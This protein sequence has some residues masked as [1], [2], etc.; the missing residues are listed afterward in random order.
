MSRRPSSYR[1]LAEHHNDEYVKRAR[2]LGYR[3][4][5]V[6]K[7]QEIDER[8]GLLRRGTTVIDLGASPGGWSQF[9]AERVRPAG[10]IIALDILP[11]EALPDVVFIQGDFRQD[12]VLE[13]LKGALGGSGV[14]LVLSDM[15][16]NMSGMR[17]VDLVRASYLAELALDLAQQV[18]KPGGSVVV[19]TFGGSGFDEFVRSARRL[20]TQ[21]AVRK[22]K[23]SRSRSSEAY[24]VATGFRALPG[25][26]E[27]NKQG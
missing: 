6:F 7:L 25:Q 12:T 1:W 11:M 3:S 4:R 21:V 17:A 8:Y 13:Q 15:A 26:A 5:A 19:K 23:A 18:L 10:R 16:P 22:P 2:E 9:A 24:V 14:D 20:F 27:G